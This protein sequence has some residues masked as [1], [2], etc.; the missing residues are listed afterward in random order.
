MKSCW[1]YDNRK[2]Q[3]GDREEAFRLVQWLELSVTEAPRFADGFLAG[4][5]YARKQAAEAAAERAEMRA[6]L[7]QS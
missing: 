5:Q 4:I 6:A 2:V 1:P 7:K 3:S